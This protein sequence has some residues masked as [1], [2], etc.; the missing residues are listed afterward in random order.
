MMSATL[1]TLP[2]KPDVPNEDYAGATA[3]V[4]VVVD[5]AG[6]PAG[7]DSGCTHGVAWYAHNLGSTLLHRAT[8]DETSLSEALA[9]AITDVADLHRDTCDLLHPGTPSATVTAVRS[10][11]SQLEYLAL[12]D[13]PLVIRHADGVQVVTDD[14]EAQVGRRYRQHMDS[15]SAGTPEHAEALRDYVETL[16]AHRNQPDGFWVAS[17]DPRAAHEALTGTVTITDILDLAL[18]SDGAS[19]LVDRFKLTTWDAALDLIRDHGPEALIRA[20]RDA[21]VSDVEGHRWPR[22]KTTDD[23]T[24]VYVRPM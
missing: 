16:R 20:V 21:E 8:T 19:R 4:Y 2:A 17:I 7:S 1:A 11:G 12:A 5:G 18:L 23:A 14:R 24:A 10:D 6:T 13:S 3:D 9:A 15:T 22:G